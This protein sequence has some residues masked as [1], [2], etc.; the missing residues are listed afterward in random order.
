MKLS[1]GEIVAILVWSGFILLTVRKFW[2]S[3]DDASEARFLGEA[4]VGGILFTGVLSLLTPITVNIPKLSYIPEVTF[5]AVFL[6]PVIVWST[7]AGIRIFHAI[8][9]QR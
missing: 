2:K 6:F 4:R 1:I 3:S 5:W 9:N 7:Y 8:I